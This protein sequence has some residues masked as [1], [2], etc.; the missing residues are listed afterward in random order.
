MKRLTLWQLRDPNGRFTSD[1]AP[2]GEW[3]RVAEVDA[4]LADLH[5]TIAVQ[6]EDLREWRTMAN[7]LLAALNSDQPIKG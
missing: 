7:E 2:D 6:A 1:F 4:T 5:A 3:V